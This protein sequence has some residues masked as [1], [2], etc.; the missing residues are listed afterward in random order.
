MDERA[1][2]VL[3]FWLEEGGPEAWY[4]SDPDFDA[5]IRERYEWLWEEALA[6]KLD[7]WRTKPKSCL[8]LL[9]VLDQ[10][11]R[12]MFRGS[13]K[14]FE[15]DPKALDVAVAA[16]LRKLDRR[17]DM[18]ERQ[19]FYLP[20][21]HSETAPDQ[22]RAVRLFTIHEPEG[23]NLQHARAHRHIIRS[24]GRFPYRNDVLGRKSTPGE[25]AFLEAGGYGAALREVKAQA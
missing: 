10:F 3:R 14:S 23:G 2:D 17:I 21:M 4:R 18:P 12:N 7:A 1:R 5:L 9:I 24:F 16:L 13:A 15:S 22:D 6:G 11:P 25:L 20:L 8:A 19:F